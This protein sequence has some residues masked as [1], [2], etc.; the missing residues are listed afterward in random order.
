MSKLTVCFVLIL[1]PL[2]IVCPALGEGIDIG[3]K[4]DSFL[5]AYNKID[6]QN[7]EDAVERLVNI[8]IQIRKFLKEV[9]M[10]HGHDKYWKSDYA[11]LSLRIDHF[12]EAF[13]YE[14]A[15]LQK[16]HKI[17]PK[18]KYREYTLFSE[19]NTD[20]YCWVENP[21]NLEAA[22]QYLKE[23]PNGPYVA[24]VYKALGGFNW[25]LFNYIRFQKENLKSK[26]HDELKNE[27]EHNVLL[28]YI[29]DIANV[30]IEMQEN[31]AKDNAIKYFDAYLKTGKDTDVWVKR[32]LNEIKNGTETR[33]GIFSC[34]D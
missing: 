20:K 34:P 17:N 25:S 7:K 29:K 19:I 30:S 32:I 31:Q 21:K 3:K 18:S 11:I 15:L 23:Y 8:D 14:G 27:E 13:E 6:F 22:Y 4:L 9:R 5:I 12:T 10:Q 33:Y 2:S 26:P 24:D 28:Q 1:L 16:A